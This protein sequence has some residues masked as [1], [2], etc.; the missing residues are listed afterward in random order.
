MYLLTNY[1]QNVCNLYSKKLRIVLR[2]CHYLKV[3]VQNGI[4]I[5]ETYNDIKGL[6]ILKSKSTMFSNNGW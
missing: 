2:K 1:W 6:L 4:T 5:K 3:R